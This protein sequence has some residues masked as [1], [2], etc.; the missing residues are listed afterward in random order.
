MAWLGIDRRALELRQAATR[1][2]EMHEAKEALSKCEEVREERHPH[3]A[4][5]EMNTVSSW[6]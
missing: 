3:D 4:E 2:S 1:R 5:I 6:R